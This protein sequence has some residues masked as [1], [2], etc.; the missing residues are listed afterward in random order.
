MKKEFES[1]ISQC[2]LIAILRG[3]T[4]EEAPSVSDTL[5]EAGF[6][7][8]EI[9]LNSPNAFESIAKASAVNGDRMMVGAGTVLTTD[10]VD[11]AHAAG[12]RFIISPN[13]YEPVI[14]RTRELGMLSMPGF[15][16]A[17]EAFDAMR[18]GA[19][20][21]KLFPA[22][23]GVTYVKDLKAVVKAPIFAVGGVNLENLPSLL[24]E[25]MGAG[26]GGALYKQGKPLEKVAEDARALVK[27]CSNG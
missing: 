6:R 22:R 19:D 2:P 16:T 8:M 11:Q 20:Y 10:D 23:L 24:K 14:R 17:S 5:Y 27:A 1:F 25:C 18:A 12:A 26:I 21:L 9:P 3:I 7:L 15:F 13:T 4:T